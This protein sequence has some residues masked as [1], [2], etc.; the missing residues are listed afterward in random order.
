MGPTKKGAEARTSEGD[1]CLGTG[2]K[3]VGRDKAVGR[4]RN[5]FVSVWG[6]GNAPARSTIY[7]CTKKKKNRSVEE[8]GQ[9]C[10]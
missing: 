5:V 6:F 4:K 8:N 3:N 10:P 7:S 1:T 2:K 9:A